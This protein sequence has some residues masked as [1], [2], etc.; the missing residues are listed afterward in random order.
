M[1]NPDM[2]HPEQYITRETRA[3]LASPD[4]WLLNEQGGPSSSGVNVSQST[5]LNFS[6]VFAAVRILSETIAS[7]PLVTYRRTAKGK[8]RATKNPA[9]ELLHDAPNPETTALAFREA[10]MGHVL[11]W[12]NGYAEIRRDGSGMPRELWLIPP[13]IV[14]PM[15]SPEGRIVYEVRVGSDRVRLDR[16]DVLHVAGLGYDGIIGYSPIRKLRDAIGLGISAENAQSAFFANGSRPSGALKF[17]GKLN[18]DALRHIRESWR[19]S[20]QGSGNTGSVP[21]LEQGLE[22]QSLGIPP[23]DAAYL[24]TRRWQL[25]EIAAA[26]RIPV[27][28]LGDMSAGASYASIEQMSLEFTMYSLRPWLVRIEQELNRKIFRLAGDR[29]H[30]AEHLVDGLLRGDVATRYNAY[31][32]GREGGWLSVNDIRRLENMDT[33]DQDGGDEYLR[34]L[35]MAT[36]STP[37]AEPA[38]R[39]SEMD[40][41]DME[42]TDD[43]QGFSVEETLRQR[44]Q[45]RDRYAGLLH[46]AV[47]RVIKVET[48]AARRSAKKP[49]GDFRSWLASYYSEGSFED[50]VFEIL[51]PVVDVVTRSCFE[52]VEG[53]LGRDAGDPTEVVSKLAAGMSRRHAERSRRLVQDLEGEALSDELA[54]WGNDRHDDE[55]S[56]ELR[57]L[58]QAAIV[59]AY[60]SAN[61]AEVVWKNRP[62]ST[63]QYE[64]LE[65]RAASVGSPIVSSG[66]KLKADGSTFENRRDLAHPP[67]HRGDCSEVL[68]DELTRK[69]N[70]D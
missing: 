8:A 61:V 52:L 13:D 59:A 42:S 33:V 24:E 41:G 2:L 29:D 57:R 22:W 5:A 39:S 35:N 36:I 53:E 65:G 20:Y 3:S 18:D 19:G 49:I 12:G 43:A 58:V 63:I 34:P 25:R 9:Y 48:N 67:L 37:V 17:P 31:K 47:G 10:L 26:Y 6:A 60:R 68:A 62:E 21:I 27:H 66:E 32:V 15:R 70:N 23:E 69:Q 45:L 14:T 55:S 44:D 16:D 51:H 40:G 11:T 56:I 46:D 30:F 7:L 50:K 64:Q 54:T 4:T 1:N 38:A 28:M